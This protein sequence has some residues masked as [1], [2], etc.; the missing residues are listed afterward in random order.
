MIAFQANIL[1]SNSYID[2]EDPTGALTIEAFSVNGLIGVVHL[3]K[4]TGDNDDAYDISKAFG[5]EPIIRFT[6]IPKTSTLRVSALSFD[7]T[8]GM[9]FENA[10]ATFHGAAAAVATAAEAVSVALYSHQVAETRSTTSAVTANAS[11]TQHT[12]ALK[13]VASTQTLLINV[14]AR[15]KS[16]SEIAATLQG[17]L[18]A[19]KVAADSAQRAANAADVVART[20]E[21]KANEL[22]Y[23]TEIAKQNAVCPDIVCA[24]SVTIAIAPSD[25][26]FGVF[27]ILDS[28]HTHT[29][30]EGDTAQLTLRRDGGLFGTVHVGW[31]LDFTG[32]A[33]AADFVASSGQVTFSPGDFTKTINIVTEDDT[34]PEFA[35]GFTVELV[36]VTGD[37]GRISASVRRTNVTIAP[38]DFAGLC[39]GQCQHGAA[40]TSG[41]Y[42]H[43]CTCVAGYSGRNC[44]VNINE[45]IGVTCL[46]SGTCQDLVNDY[47]C[48][49]PFGNSGKLCQDRPRCQSGQ[50]WCFKS[51][52]CVAIVSG[53]KPCRATCVNGTAFAFQTQTCVAPGLVNRDCPIPG[54]AP[55]LHG[56]VE[57]YNI[58]ENK[59]VGMFVFRVM[60]TP[61]HKWG[62]NISYSLAAAGAYGHFGIERE[63]G[64]IHTLVSLNREDRKTYVLNVSARD[65]SPQSQPS[66]TAITV[67]VADVNDNVPTFDELA[68][69]IRVREDTKPGTM[70][71]HIPVSDDDI[72]LNKKVNFT[73]S[74]GNVDNAFSIDALDG[75]LRIN[76]PLD[77]AKLE[78]YNLTITAT[79]NGVPPLNQTVKVRVFAE[80]FPAPVYS[81]KSYAAVLA[82]NV[83][84]GHQILTVRATAL[85]D[86]TN[87]D[88]VYAIKEH[89][90][91]RLLFNISADGVVSTSSTLDREAQGVH[92]LT[93]YA[94]DFNIP[95]HTTTVVVQVNLTDINDEIPTFTEMIYTVSILEEH[96]VGSRV[97][98]VA[99][100]DLDVGS[101]SMFQYTLTENRTDNIFKISPVSGEI[102]LVRE[103]EKTAGGTF[104]LAVTATDQGIP[105]Q[106][107][108]SEVRIHVVRF[109]APSFAAN[110]PATVEVIE[111]A[112]IGYVVMQLTAEAHHNQTNQGLKYTIESG[113]VEGLFAMGKDGQVL[114][115]ADIDRELIPEFLLTFRATDYGPLSKFTDVSTKII[116]GDRNDNKPYFLGIPYATNIAESTPVGTQIFTVAAKD[117]DAGNNGKLVYKIT[118]GNNES[119]F[120][121]DSVTGHVSVDRPLQQIKADAHSLEVTAFDQGDD[122]QQQ[123]NPEIVSIAILRFDPPKFE[124]ASYSGMINEN[125]K[126][127]A[128][129]HVTVSAAPMHTDPNKI[130]TYAIVR[131][132]AFVDSADQKGQ[133]LDSVFTMSTSS[134]GSILASDR[135]DR[136]EFTHYRLVVQAQDYALV[137]KTK[138]VVVDIAVNDVNDVTPAFTSETFNVAVLEEH[139]VDSRVTQVVA[140]DTDAGENGVITYVTL[141][142]CI[143]RNR[144]AC[145]GVASTMLCIYIQRGAYIY[146]L[147]LHP[148]ILYGANILKSK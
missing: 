146:L 31:R 55:A 73:I 123:S 20:A 98:Q 93:V 3:A 4:G 43:T 44:E 46:N 87:Q 120:T 47:Q 12:D 23:A 11:E 83:S 132:V 72:N 74:E 76:T 94:T 119:A 121:I 131:T 135:L 115:S 27:G 75:N 22:V 9:T 113:N 6:V 127:M 90:S 71:L 147:G 21:L 103:L 29:V 69:D 24:A 41:V 50:A 107:S 125:S 56:P 67:H 95:P 8:A 129:V 79:D 63:T 84:A 16:A 144:R 10:N 77:G 145:F 128:Y 35:E 105:V 18:S 59:D 106:Q 140:Q 141:T 138:T 7:E 40:C 108:T 26:A 62:R 104:V 86:G 45:C 80:H 52:K 78:R 42:N 148:Y 122:T 88:I 114:V 5:Y 1:L 134:P 111:H 117:V 130:I 143:H 133:V 68:Y 48:K 116:I 109:G 2:Q 112:S 97:M 61:L 39:T 81:Q 101:N 85:H 96:A 49:C 17:A 38:S 33:D 25:D 51:Q 82:E 60:A 57:L 19:A 15:F 30:D 64:A 34:L 102:T 126:R 53:N 142:R 136:E 54:P 66:F 36:G 37:G 110:T 13:K 92:T 137:A 32:D 89:G 139:A 70:I 65:D 58:S 14:L 91:A 100:T 118:S 124:A 99:A 28:S